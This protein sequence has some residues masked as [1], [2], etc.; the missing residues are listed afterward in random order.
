M[1]KS[2]EFSDGFVYTKCGVRVET[3]SLLDC[4]LGVEGTP[5][6]YYKQLNLFLRFE[7]NRLRA[8]RGSQI[9]LCNALFPSEPK[10]LTGDVGPPPPGISPLIK[11]LTNRFSS[12]TLCSPQ[13]QNTSP[14]MSGR[15]LPASPPLLKY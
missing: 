4:I 2:L 13:S 8:F 1:Q 9:F 5:T 7:T 14:E 6:H 3:K 10:H 15:P 11:I 12:A